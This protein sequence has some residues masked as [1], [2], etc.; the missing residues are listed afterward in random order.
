[1]SRK[2]FV[3]AAR[4]IREHF[5]GPEHAAAVELIVHL[6]STFNRRFDEAR[7]RKAAG[8]GQNHRSESAARRLA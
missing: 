6:G 8:D 5:A 3:E 7:F 2:H 1:L 4:F